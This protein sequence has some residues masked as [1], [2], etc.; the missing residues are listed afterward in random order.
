MLQNSFNINVEKLNIRIYGAQNLPSY[1]G[2][3]K[4]GVWQ[5]RR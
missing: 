4:R 1:E 5:T 2:T 3:Y